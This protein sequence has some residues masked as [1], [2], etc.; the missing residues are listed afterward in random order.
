METENN[1][2][3]RLNKIEVNPEYCKEW[4]IKQKDFYCLTQDGKLLR[5][6]LY[7]IG[8]INNPKVGEDKYFM[9]MKHIESFYP[10]NI[11]EMAKSAYKGKKLDPK[12][13][14]FRWC[15]LDEYG[16]E[17]VEFTG[18]NHASIVDNSCIYSVGSKFYNIESGLLYCDASGVIKSDDFLFLENNYD[19]D[20]SK[21]GVLKINKFDGTFELFPKK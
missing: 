13:L 19:K 10:K 1:K 4:N 14:E 2:G 5:P 7:R 20:K 8:G 16:N 12:Y 17:K 11:L 6:T 21:R 9:L 18:L 15:I 3:L